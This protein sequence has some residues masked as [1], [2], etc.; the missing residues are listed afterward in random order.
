V[1]SFTDPERDPLQAELF[2]NPPKIEGGW[3]T[4]NEAPGLGLTL[5]EAAVKKF[6][7]P[8]FSSK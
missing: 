3:L 6:G 1:E 5:S 2:E 4:L 8:I 7:T